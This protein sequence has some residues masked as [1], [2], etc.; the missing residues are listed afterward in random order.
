MLIWI[1]IVGSLMFYFMVGYHVFQSRNR[2]KSI[3]ASKSRDAGGTN[4]QKPRVDFLVPQDCFYGRIVTEVQVVQ[5]TASSSALPA[6]PKTAYKPATTS[7]P[8]VSFELPSTS[9]PPAAAAPSNNQPYFSN[10][11]TITSTPA[12]P[13]RRR[14][15]WRSL[16]R[17]VS[18]VVNKFVVDDPIKRAYLRTSLLFALSVL[19][20]WIPSSMNRI[21]SWLMGGSPFAYHVATAAVLPLQGL[22]NAVIFFITSSTGLRETWRCRRDEAGVVTILGQ[23]QSQVGMGQGG[24]QLTGR[25]VDGDGD[26]DDDGMRGGRSFMDDDSES[27]SHVELRRMAEAPGKTSSSL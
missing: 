21:H 16:R 26:E 7:S 17:S 3:S 6:E 23:Q 15:P 2:L 14:H 13:P 9:M 5:S 12:P 11:S 8:S 1:C 10:F 25:D 4:E 18:R 24:Q 19:A 20:T 27:G 22:W